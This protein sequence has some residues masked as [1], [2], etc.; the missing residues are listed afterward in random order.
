MR[1]PKLYVILKKIITKG[2]EDDTADKQ[3]T[4]EKFYKVFSHLGT[5]I[6]A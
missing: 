1:T 5:V 6:L 3:K 4:R 2:E